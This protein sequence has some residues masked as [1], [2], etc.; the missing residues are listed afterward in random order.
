MKTPKICADLRSNLS[1][2]LFFA[3]HHGLVT[4][5]KILLSIE[6]VNYS[7]PS[8]PLWLTNQIKI[9]VDYRSANIF[10]NR[11]KYSTYMGIKCTNGEILMRIL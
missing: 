3:I 4:K 2:Y 8:M 1:I 6:L 5:L 11:F 9:H 10:S 7:N